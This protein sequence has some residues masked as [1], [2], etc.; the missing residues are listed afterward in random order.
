[1]IRTLWFGRF[2]GNWPVKRSCTYTY[3]HM[4]LVCIH[5][6]GNWVVFLCFGS[7]TQLFKVVK[8]IIRTWSK[9]FIEPF[10]LWNSFMN[11][12]LWINKMYEWLT[13]VEYD[14]DHDVVYFLLYLNCE[15]DMKLLVFIYVMCIYVVGEFSYMSLVLNFLVKACTLIDV[16]NVVNVCIVD[17]VICSRNTCWVGCLHPYCCWPD[18]CIHI[19]IEIIAVDNDVLLASGVTTSKVIWYHTCLESI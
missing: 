9:I 18:T 7:L 4:W 17:W 12:L 10:L 3:I 5:S 2:H 13:G 8:Y 14:V 1:M 16:E 11:G 19:A 6:Q 15:N